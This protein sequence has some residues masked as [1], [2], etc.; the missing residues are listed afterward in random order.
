MTVSTSNSKSLEELSKEKLQ[1]EIDQIKRNRYLSFLT[2][3]GIFALVLILAI[4]FISTI[5]EFNQK[6]YPDNSNLT[7]QGVLFT[8]G[9][10]TAILIG[11]YNLFTNSIMSRIDERTIFMKDDISEL[12]NDVSTLKNDVSTLKNDVSTLKNDVSTLKNDV[13]VI[14]DSLIRIENKLNP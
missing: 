5:I 14:K 11:G 12:K 7:I 10:V 9:S 8:I 3:F 13:G 2:F 4:Q 1:L 6:F